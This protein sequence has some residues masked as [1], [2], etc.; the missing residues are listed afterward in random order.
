MKGDFKRVC[1][2]WHVTCEVI[3]V[4]YLV[5]L[6]CSPATDMRGFLIL[7]VGGIVLILPL[8]Y[9]V[10]NLIFAWSNLFIGR[11]RLYK[12][13]FWLLL[14]NSAGTALCMVT[15]VSRRDISERSVL[16][17]SSLAFALAARNTY[18]GLE[19]RGKQK[20]TRS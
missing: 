1:R 18:F 5:V 20:K 17:I 11:T 12:W 10:G 9:F 13:M 16:A 4:A 15:A 19:P 6:V 14:I 2:A 8:M 3:L 7:G